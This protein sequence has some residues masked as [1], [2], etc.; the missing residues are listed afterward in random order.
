[1]ASPLTLASAGISIGSSILGGIQGQRAASASAG[2][3]MLQGLATIMQGQSQ[4]RMHAYQ[5]GV[6]RR[7]AQIMEQNADY[8]LIQG[9]QEAVR[10]GLQAR[11]QKGQIIA[12]QSASGLDIASG[13]AKLVQ[14]SQDK[15][16]RMD[17]MQINQNAVKA[18]FDYKVQ[19]Y[20]QE[21]EA[22]L[23]EMA[24]RNAMTSG[25]FGGIIG[26]QTASR[27]AS[28]QGTSSLISSAGSVADK[29]LQASKLMPSF[30]L[31]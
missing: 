20:A 31:G 29:W 1:M 7:N 15:L 22:K 23:Q 28:I 11:Q 10:Y 13:S 26:S 18:A 27:A 5:A 6:A 14:E 4:Q 17:F 9:G 8:E 30:S 12:Q 3:G 21:E 2:A 24:G 16:T 19:A 25:L